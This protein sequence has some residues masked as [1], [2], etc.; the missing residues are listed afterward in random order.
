MSFKHFL[1]VGVL[2]TFAFSTFLITEAAAQD[3]CECPD[4]YRAATVR[5]VVPVRRVARSYKAKRVYRASR[6][7]STVSIVRYQPF[8][9]PVREAV[10]YDENDCGESYAPATRVVVTE[11]VYTAYARRTYTTSGVYVG[12]YYDAERIGRGWGR[13][14]GFKDGWKAA[15]KYRPYDPENN[16][17]FRDANNGYKSRFGDKYLY[18]AAYREG[19]ISGYDSGW[20]SINGKSRAGVV[21]Y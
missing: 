8:Y 10:I 14:D 12:S 21:R 20:R 19:Y 15:L 11:P 7:R 2:L 9:V 5:K 17:D 13:R 6:S 1:R 3:Y 4:V 18:K 16:G